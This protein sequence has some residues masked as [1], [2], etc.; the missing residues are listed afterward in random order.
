M[1]FLLSEANIVGLELDEAYQS[2]LAETKA[3]LERV[4]KLYI[5]M[6]EE[7]KIMNKQ[8]EDL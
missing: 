4:R 3:E 7:N 8:N 2:E 6:I 5:K 1:Q